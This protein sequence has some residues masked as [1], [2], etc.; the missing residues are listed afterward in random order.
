LLKESV[1]WR[2]IDAL[3]AFLL[4]SSMGKERENKVLDK[5]LDEYRYLSIQYL[6]SPIVFARFGKVS[7]YF[8]EQAIIKFEF[9]I[10]H[11]RSFISNRNC[12]NYFQSFERNRNILVESHT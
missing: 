4:A 7:N 6:A 2:S 1:S 10:G 11:H 5:H 12:F 3:K 9:S 8:C